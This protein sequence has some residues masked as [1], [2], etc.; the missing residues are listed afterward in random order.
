MSAVELEVLTYDHLVDVAKDAWEKSIGPVMDRTAALMS[1]EKFP[2]SI[3][4]FISDTI[5]GATRQAIHKAITTL[6]PRIHI[7]LSVSAMA[8]QAYQKTS[9]EARKSITPSILVLAM[10]QVLHKLGYEVDGDEVTIAFSLTDAVE[11]DPDAPSG[12]IDLD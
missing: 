8:Q 7:T 10:Q 12:A 5:H 9:A 6:D 4:R 2:R 11:P 3:E 1:G